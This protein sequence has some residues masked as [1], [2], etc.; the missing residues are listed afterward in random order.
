MAR[1]ARVVVPGVPYHI[2]HRGNERRDVFFCDLDRQLYLADLAVWSHDCGLELWGYCLMTN[3]VHLLGVPAHPD[4][5]ARAIGWTHQ[6]H[7]RRVHA[8]HGCTGHLWANR[9]HS[10]ALDDPHLWTAIRYV[11]LNPVRAGL[12]ARAADWA[13]SSAR[14]H[15]GVGGD[16]APLLAAARP[17]GGPRPHPL[18]GLPISWDDWLGLGAQEDSSYDAIRLATQTGRPCGDEGFVTTLERQ[19]GR[20]LSPQKRGP[21]PKTTEEGE[22]QSCLF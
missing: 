3:H 18:T 2:T 13:W 20:S 21:K 9:F 6:R 17:F 12:V 1:L 15:G 14:A 7:A 10:T 11:E 5:L 8:Q 22:D 4:S 16:G 19:L